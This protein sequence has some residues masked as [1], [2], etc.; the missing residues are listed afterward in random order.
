ML[1]D[2][3]E[4]FYRA[5]NGLPI[6]YFWGYKTAG[7][8][9]S[10]QDILEWEEAGK[11]V[12][13]ANPKPG[14]VKYVDVTG[15]GIIDS[16]DK[17][18][19]G[20]GMPDFTFGFNISLDYKGFDFSINAYGAMGNEIVQSYRNHSNKQANYT[21]AV[22]DRWTGEGTSNRMPRVTETNVNWQFS[23]L[24]IHDGDYLRISNISL[25]YDFAKLM[26]L[27]SISRA[28]LYVQG[29][30]LFTLTKYNG[31]DPEIGYGT[32]G[33]V[34]GIDLGYYPRPAIM[35]AGVNLSF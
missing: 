7:I 19:L 23:D 20:S 16:N 1:Y 25:G 28:R 11:G 3:S 24:Y 31:M 29:Q 17:G 13:Q 6:G 21:S 4:E 12:L 27:K 34:S 35:M 2:N 15:N 5:Q 8:F 30:N 26:N 9:Q 22:L 18:N 32:E 10:E 14:D 33:W